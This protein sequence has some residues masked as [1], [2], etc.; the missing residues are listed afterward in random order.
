LILACL[1]C[2]FQAYFAKT[3]NCF[4]YFWPFGTIS[5]LLKIK[6]RFE[7]RQVKQAYL[8]E[9]AALLKHVW[10]TRPKSSNHAKISANKS[11]K[12]GG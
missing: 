8:L 1:T 5:I 11:N 10:V 6:V 12:R 9:Q 4:Y 7:Q 3:D 2:S